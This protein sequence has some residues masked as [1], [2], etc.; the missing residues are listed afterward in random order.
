MPDDLQPRINKFAMQYATMPDIA[1]PRQIAPLLTSA[2]FH[3]FTDASISAFSAVIYARQPPSD[4]APAGLVFFLGKSRVAPIEQR[5]V[6]KLEL[7]AAVLGVR[8]LRTVL[9]AF[10]CNFRQVFFGPIVASIQ[11]QIK[12]E[13]FVAHRENELVQHKNPKQ[14]HHVPTELNPADHGTRGLK[15]S[16]ISPKRTKGPDFLLNPEKD[17]PSRLPANSDRSIC[18]P[19]VVMPQTG[20]ADISRFSSWNRLLKKG[21]IVRFFVRRLRDPS[22]TPNLTANDFQLATET[23]LRQSQLASF[24]AILGKLLRKEPLSSEDKLLSLNPFI[25]ERQFIRSS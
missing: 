11:N 1:V 21:A 2:D 6:P 24:P 3:I 4:T 18:T 12:P 15:P 14:W 17:W 20:L 19:T 16:D 7:E 10:E 8:L 13:T 22:S 23:L 5:S 9:N 25:D